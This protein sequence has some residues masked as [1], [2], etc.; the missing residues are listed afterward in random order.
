MCLGWIGAGG[1]KENVDLVR[2]TVGA[3]PAVISFEQYV[4]QIRVAHPS[5]RYGLPRDNP[6]VVDIGEG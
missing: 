4:A 2:R 1:V 5:V 6:V 3:K